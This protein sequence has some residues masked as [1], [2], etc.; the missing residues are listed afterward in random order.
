[1]MTFRMNWKFTACLAPAF[2][3]AACAT[4]EEAV[5]EKVAETYR[6]DLTGAQVVGGGDPDGSA[7]AEVSV[8]DRL[9]Q[10]CYD[11]NNINA[12]GPITGIM[13][14]RGA[15]G[16]NGPAVLNMKHANEGGWKGCTNRSEWLEESI[17]RNFTSYYVMIHTA[18]YPNGAV[19]GQLH[20]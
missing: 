10:I 20:Q 18:E 9:D 7:K 8:A 6:A 19:R 1:M 17:D 4:A 13:I 16:A 5:V 15:P 11:I 12:L 3:L 2:A 14:H